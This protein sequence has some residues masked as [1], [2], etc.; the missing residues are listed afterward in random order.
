MAAYSDM[1]SAAIAVI[2]TLSDAY[3]PYFI[4]KTNEGTIVPSFLDY[5][6]CKRT[7]KISLCKSDISIPDCK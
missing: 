3:F 5:Y 6:F 7:S 2:C 4:E 1:K